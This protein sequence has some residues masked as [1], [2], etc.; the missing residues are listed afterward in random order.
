MFWPMSMAIYA[1]SIFLLSS[2][3]TFVY[4]KSLGKACVAV[5]C[6]QASHTGQR[7]TGAGIAF[8]AAWMGSVVLVEGLGF[9]S[10]EGAVYKLFLLS[11]PLVVVSFIDDFHSLAIVPRLITQFLVVAGMLIVFGLPWS[12]NHT[13]LIPA[14]FGLLSVSLVGGINFYNFMDGVDGLLGGTAAAQLLFLGVWLHAPTLWL[15]A[16]C[17]GGFLVWNRPPYR[18]FMGDVGSTALGF[19]VLS[20]FVVYAPQLEAVH[21]F[22]LLPLLGDALYT[23]CRRLTAGRNVIRAHRSHVYQRFDRAGWGHFRITVMY[24]GMTLVMGAMVSFAG[25]LGAM[26]GCL[27][28]ILWLVWAENRLSRKGMS[29]PEAF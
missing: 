8:L 5:E 12:G 1:V 17:V 4:L 27:L 15:L 14:L 26:A 21:L 13:V 7:I 9:A 20:S 22:I 10:F 29:L 18:V 6:V 11:S 23:F 16:F 25:L 19:F 24:V 3:L 2:G 28:W